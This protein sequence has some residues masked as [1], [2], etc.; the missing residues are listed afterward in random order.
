[1]AND[2]RDLVEWYPFIPTVPE[3]PAFAASVLDLKVLVELDASYAE[4]A[5]TGAFGHIKLMSVDAYTRT[6]KVRIYS[7]PDSHP[8]FRNDTYKEIDVMVHRSTETII[9]GYSY[10]V[11]TDLE[12][13][14]GDPLEVHPDCIQFRYAAPK[15]I[16]QDRGPVLSDDTAEDDPVDVPVGDY[17]FTDGN[18]TLVEWR[19]ATV[20]FTGGS[21]LGLGIYNDP[22]YSDVATYA[23]ESNVGLR[24]INGST[25]AV[26][27]SGSDTIDTDVS[28]DDAAPLVI[29]LAIRVGSNEA[30]TDAQS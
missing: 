22:P 1:M 13:Y 29:S 19:N 28:L 6:A 27:I 4:A 9:R 30:S 24:S 3:M 10:M 25:D 5:A 8:L 26:S 2:I 15:L 11:V 21:G 23:V 20:M 7:N 17:V 16:L 12:D 18:N 14:A